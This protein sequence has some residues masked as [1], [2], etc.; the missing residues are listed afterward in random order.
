KGF[1]TQKLSSFWQPAPSVGG[2][3]SIENTPVGIPFN[4][5]LWV[6][7]DGETVIAALNPGDYNGTI[8]SNLSKLPPPGSKEQNW[9]ARIQLDGQ[10]SGLY[11][12]YHYIGTGDI[13]GAPQEPGVKM[14]ESIVQKEDG[15]V[16][17]LSSASDQMFNDIAGRTTRMPTYQGDLELI[18]H[19]AG[20]LTSEAYHKR[21]IIKS[22]LLGDAAEKASV[23]AEW[24]GGRSYPQERLNEAWTLVM[25]GHFHDTAAGTATPRAYEFAQNDDIIALKQF[26]D[27]LSDATESVASGLS[28]QTQGVPVVVFNPLNI[29]REDLVEAT[30]MFPGATP[31]AVRV[32]GPDGNEVPAQITDGKVLFLAKV[33]SVGYAVFDVQPANEPVKTSSP[34]RVTESSLE[35]ARY[36][37]RVDQ[38][39]D[40]SSVFDKSLEK[41][42]LSGPIQ[43][44]ISTDTPKQWPAWNMDFSDEQAKARTLVS[45]PA[46]VRIKESGPVR[47]SLEVTRE[48]EGSRFV[49]TISLSAGDPGN[50]VEFGNVVDWQ[51]KAANL[52]AVFPVSASH[53]NATYNWDI[54]TVQRPTENP[55]QFEVASHRWIDLTDKTGSFGATILTDCKNGSDKPDDHTIRLTLI[56]TPGLPRGA[57]DFSDQLSQDWGR[58]EF[59]FGL[60]GHPGNWRQAQTDWQAYRFNDP[61]VAFQTSKHA[62]ALGKSFS[63]ATIDNPR[64]RVLALKK[65]EM[66]D[67]VILRMVELD[68]KPASHV[69]VS[70]A[71]GINAAHEVNGQEEARGNAEL[72][73]GSLVTSFVGYQPRTFALKLAS[74]PVKLEGVDSR[75]V[76]LPYDLAV[77]SNDDTRSDPGFDAKGNAL[78]AEMLPSELG[79]NGV[80]FQLAPAATGSKNA[81]VTKGQTI[82]LPP[83]E[84][85]RVYI[86][87]ASADG[88][89]KATFSVGEQATEI[90]V[91]D[92]GGFVGQWDTRVWKH[93]PVRDWAISAHHA[94]WPPPKHWPQAWEPRYPKDYAGLRPGFIKPAIPA[95]FASH[96]HT[97][98]GLNEPYQYSYLFAYAIPI[99][100]GAKTLKLPNNESIRIVAVT[101]A[102]SNPDTKPAQPLLDDL[103]HRDQSATRQ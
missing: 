102:S 7:P 27:V 38:N 28:T 17:V 34:L 56:R 16:H 65:A 74:P 89:Q 72:D 20:S 21:W 83:G 75:P 55:R 26:G 68:G 88:D 62:G 2:P 19:S 12:D 11:A 81:L 30:L 40:L 86:L 82:D 6:G 33:P 95:W 64:I 92:W 49:Q 71:G 93:E 70:F 84:F 77:A 99:P 46:H 57:K 37:V 66:S 67:E 42:L 73:R 94:V 53:P 23:A 15:P 29:A 41:E 14:L 91:A 3:G 50:R 48:A 103:G 5:G 24:M 96:H 76:K 80:V 59:R 78:P 22:E 51:G 47:V 13:G 52:K 44:A 61:L 98:S 1:S 90:T 10:V 32:Y 60:A 45:G 54:G 39:G 35:N 79:Y 9:P 4:V 97:A 100:P 58:H 43:L 85:N 69:R 31:G 8:N 87:A 63:L 18:N 101:V 25:G 36:R